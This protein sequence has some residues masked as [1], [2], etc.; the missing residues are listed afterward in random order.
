MRERSNSLHD[1]LL[2]T[3]FNISGSNRG[4]LGFFTSLL[5]FF[6]CLLRIKYLEV[7]ELPHP[8]HFTH[9]HSA[10]WH[11]E[12]GKQ[13]G[14]PPFLLCGLKHHKSKDVSPLLR[15]TLDR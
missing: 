14:K 6:I 11:N 5:F 12:L 7:L 8:I 1:S 15:Y 3:R 4:N 10:C 13:F 2:K 9:V